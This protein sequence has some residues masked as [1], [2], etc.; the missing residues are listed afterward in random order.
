[1]LGGARA[2]VG[3]PLEAGGATAAAA[4]GVGTRSI[5]SVVS[6]HLAAAALALFQTKWKMGYGCLQSRTGLQFMR[7][8]DLRC[9]LLLVHV[10]GKGKRIIGK[11][12]GSDVLDNKPVFR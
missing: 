7:G 3:C 12:G 6:I 8:F 5:S 4:D 9:V 1:M 11:K 2:A 10:R